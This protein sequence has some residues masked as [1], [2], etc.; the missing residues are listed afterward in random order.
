[1]STIE[2][3]SSAENTTEENV[4]NTPP[5]K[6]S[7]AAYNAEALLEYLISLTLID[8]FLAVL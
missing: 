1:M 4:Y 8:S 6:R 7:R 2:N 3:K 5:Y